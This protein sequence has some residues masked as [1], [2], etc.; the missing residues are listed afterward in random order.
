V[1]ES[2]VT[3]KVLLG[4]AS[5][6]LLTDQSGQAQTVTNRSVCNTASE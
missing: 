2:A 3:I 5:A 1:V 6:M 4:K